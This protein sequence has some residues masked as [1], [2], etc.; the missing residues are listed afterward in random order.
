MLNVAILKPL[1]NPGEIGGSI[2]SLSEGET[3][4]AS[5]RSGEVVEAVLGMHKAQELT[6]RPQI[7]RRNE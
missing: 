5:V 3:S 6:P 2:E 7:D 1:N 4:W